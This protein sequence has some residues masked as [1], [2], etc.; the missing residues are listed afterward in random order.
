[1]LNPSH[2]ALGNCKKRAVV[3]IG[4]NSVRLVVYDGPARAPLAICN[5]KA[6]C[7]LG[8]NMTPDGRLDPE[9]VEL[10]LTTLKRFREVLRQHGEPE[11]FAIATA[12]VRAAADGEAFV[13]AVRDIGFEVTVISGAEEAL[14]AAYGVVSFEPG[15][16]GL[17]GDMGGGSLELIRLVN[18]D[19]QESDSLPIGPL[20]IMRKV[21]ESNKS[22]TQLIAKALDAV[23]F[24]NDRTI[25]K[26]YVVGGAW[27]AIAR[28]HMSQR[29][30]PLAVLHHYEMPSAHAL[31]ICQLIA[32]QSPG[33]LASIPGIPRRR[34][35]T[36]PIAAAVLESIIH[37]TK[38]KK[39]VVS[40]G[41]VREGLL[42][43]A[44]H[45]AERDNDPLLE[46]AYFFAS[47]FSP[48]AADQTAYEFLEPLFKNAKWGTPRV[49]EATAALIDIA[50]YFHPAP[51]G[52]QAFQ[53][54]LRSPFAGI[55]HE[56]RVWIALALYHRHEGRSLPVNEPVLD[57]LNEDALESAIQ[58]GLALRFVAALSPKAPTALKGCR[59]EL[60]DGRLVFSA[61][62]EKEAFMGET[63]RR[64]FEGL[65]NALNVRAVEI[66]A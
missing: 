56:E 48:D 10:A 11:T 32:Q 26:L 65:A 64:R 29:N 38:T 27:R 49:R 60:D 58:Y 13:E 51:R 8:R 30:Y 4:S 57:L 46:A 37:R 50:A 15:A 53:M 28:I 34:I 22:Q 5:E 16:T 45:E 43:R 25:D 1:M 39:V 14:L 52:L 20:S 18:G 6:L 19:L 21:A 40:A 3:D 59:L 36:L 24:A 61:P 31:G 54:A 41:G 63:P 35:D 23:P 7:G 17:A 55:R 66:S 44:L 42:Y 47:K 62:G 33:S 12:A 9:A 2:T